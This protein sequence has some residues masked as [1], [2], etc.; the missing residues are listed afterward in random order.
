[1][2]IKYKR[3]L[4]YLIDIVIVSLIVSLLAG[5]NIM[6]KQMDK[7]N[8]ANI[9]LEEQSEKI[10]SDDE[11]TEEDEEELKSIIYDINYFGIAYNVL[12]V[13][14]IISYFAIFQYF[15][16][17]KTI[18]KKI[19]KIKVVSKD[20]SEL[21]L[22]N[23]LLRTII[24]YNIVFTVINIGGAEFL[25]FNGFYTVYI[26]STA[27]NSVVSIILFFMILFRKDE[28]G[29]HDIISSSKVVED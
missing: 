26:I 22:V 3:L 24:L 28:R 27:I 18:G 9:R 10:L 11:I 5:S 13:V 4:A 15:N 20:D 7:Y 29:L 19:L 16:K 21:S 17:G 25:K 8:D 12:D 14:V 6:Q 2:K 1:M 23:Y